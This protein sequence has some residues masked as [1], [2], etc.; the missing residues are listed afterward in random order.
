[1]SEFHAVGRLACLAA[2]SFFSLED[3]GPNHL[4][5]SRN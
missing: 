4:I 3:A 2:M 1:L 5:A